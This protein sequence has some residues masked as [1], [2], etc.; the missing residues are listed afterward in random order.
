MVLE[1]TVN[2]QG[3]VEKVKVVDDSGDDKR[4]ARTAAALEDTARY[5]PRFENGE[6]VVTDGVVFTQGW[7]LLLPPPPAT[8]PASPTPAPAPQRAN[9]GGGAGACHGLSYDTPAPACSRPRRCSHAPS[10]TDG[11]SDSRKTRWYQTGNRPH[12]AM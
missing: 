4:A 10:S 3:R 7:T 11:A 12:S 9:T 6:P 8:A 1:F 5:R 2:T